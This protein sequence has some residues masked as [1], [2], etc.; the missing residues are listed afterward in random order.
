MPLISIKLLN[1]QTNCVTIFAVFVRNFIFLYPANIDTSDMPD[2]EVH[3]RYT[4]KFFS[5]KTRLI[6]ERFT[7]I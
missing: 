1:F 7:L 2:F 6:F 5:A 4:K 3:D